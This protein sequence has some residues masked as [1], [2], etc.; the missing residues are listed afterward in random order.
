MNKKQLI[1]AWQR[2]MNKFFLNFIDKFLI[3]VAIFLGFIILAIWI[4][5]FFS[6]LP[7]QKAIEIDIKD[8]YYEEELLQDLRDNTWPPQ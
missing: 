6:P 5:P 7:W 2:T 4:L 3:F 8:P 1:V